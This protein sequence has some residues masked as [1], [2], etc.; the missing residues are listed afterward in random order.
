MARPRSLFT[1]IILSLVIASSVCSPSHSSSPTYESLKKCKLS[2]TTGECSVESKVA[3]DAAAQMEY[4]RL[5]NSGLLVSRLSYSAWIT[6]GEQV[7][8]QKAFEI[9]KLCIDAGINL[10][11]NA[12]AYNGGLAEIVMGKA[13]QRLVLEYPIPREHLVITTKIFFGTARGHGKHLDRDRW[14][15]NQR[16]LSR[17]HIV[18]GTKASLKRLQLDYVDVVYAHRYDK[19]TPME[20]IV[21]AFN[22]VIDQG[23]AFYWCTS[24]W[25]SADIRHAIEVARRLGMVGPICEQP[26]YNMLHRARFESEYLP[27][28]K[29]YDYGTTIW[30]ALSSGMLTGKYNNGIPEGSRLSLE[31]AS[32]ILKAFQDGSRHKGMTFDDVVDVARKI[33]AIALRL[34]CSTAQLAVAWVLKNEHVTSVILGATKLHQLEDTFGALHVASDLLDGATMDEIEGVLGNKPDAERDWNPNKSLG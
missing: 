4:R 10:F 21:R 9:M 16:G 29:D 33:G 2:S 3:S 23:M 30:S 17:K 8:E 28:Y 24:E 34:G 32:Y 19:H 18:E 12:E 13:L 7:D 6:F 22:W 26:Q 11:D 31:S 25:S 15:P 20:E 1:F 5:G 27:L 14:V